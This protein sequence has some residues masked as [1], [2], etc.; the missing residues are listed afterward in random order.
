MKKSHRDSDLVLRELLELSELIYHTEELLKKFPDDFALIITLK[1]DKQRQKDLENELKKAQAEQRKHSIIYTFKGVKSTAKLP[2]DMVIENL[3]NFKSLLVKT[4]KFLLNT[5]QPFEQ[6]YFNTLVSGSM[7]LL[8]TTSIDDK[9]ISDFEIVFS[10]VFDNINDLIKGDSQIIQDVVSKSFKNNIK[11][12]R[13]Y[14]KLFEVTAKFKNDIC[15]T[16]ESFKEKKHD[17]DIDYQKSLKVYNTLKKY[18]SIPEQNVTIYGII[19]GISLIKNKVEFLTQEKKG[20]LIRC[21]FHETLINDIKRLFNLPTK[22]EFKLRR[23]I[24]D[25][26]GEEKDFWTLLRFIE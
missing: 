14:R 8:L 18:I 20:R 24:N 10:F 9:L 21:E 12:I 13:N 26:T 22:A 19:K 17:I 25:I 1:Q 4:S 7:G 15:I 11:L 3:E 16:W 2:V 5:D 6:L 23:E